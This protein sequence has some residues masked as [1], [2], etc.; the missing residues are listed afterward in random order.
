MF[1][2]LM[3]VYKND[4]LEFFDIALR[5]IYDQTF[6]PSQIVLV[7]DGEL[8]SCFYESIAFW[9]ERFSACDIEF[10]EVRLKYNL[11]LG[12]ALREGS[13]YC[14]QE[15]IIRMDSDDI[16]LDN[17]FELT[18]SAIKNNPEASVIGGQI[19]EFYSDIGDLNRKRLV[20][21]STADITKF[22]KKR[23][24]MNHVT[25][26]IRK[27]CLEGVGNYESVIFHEDYYLW[28]KLLSSNYKLI[29]IPDTL[30]MVRTGNDL[31]GRR[32]GLGYFNYEYNFIRKCINIGYM[33]KKEATKY[34]F[35]RLFFRVMPKFM[36]NNV[37]K[38]LRG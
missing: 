12:G 20:P 33:N 17:R 37:Y 2:V 30:V 38:R 11:G 3:S 13:R 32:I 16:S 10:E 29:N 19:E 7:C 27:G 34:L 22:G 25:V 36:L 24:P 6:K 14:N 35:P 1:S 18:C 28:V 26:C 4:N 31:I 23:N 21:L 9:S 15:F 5:S 8:P